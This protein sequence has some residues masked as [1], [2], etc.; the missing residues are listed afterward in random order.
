MTASTRNDVPAQRHIDAF[1]EMMSAERGAAA[2]TLDAYGRDLSAY[3]A[4]LLVRRRAATEAAPADVEAFAAAMRS[5][6][7]SRAT[8]MRRLSAVRQ[9]HRFLYAEQVAADNPAAGVASPRRARPLP[10]VL[11]RAEVEAMLAAA[12]EAVGRPASPARRLKALKVRC[13]VELLAST[14]L[15][16][17]ELLALPLRTA[18]VADGIVDVRGKGGR[19]RLVPVSARALDAAAAYAGAV[20]DDCDTRKRPLPR[21]LFPGRDGKAA[22]TRQAAALEL[23]ALAISAGLD[24][25]RVHPHVL[26]HAFA[27]RLV[28]AGADLRAVQQLL[29][30][31]DISTT[32]IYTHVAGER[33]RQVVETHH[34]LAQ[35]RTGQRRG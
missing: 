1:L 24:P 3:A 19:E 34:P 8:Q 32:Q 4:F 12:A 18:Q 9:F 2:N 11:T 23:K 15:R 31:A 25:A 10:D 35:A 13:L 30:H 33:L 28:D 21:F 22:M 29:G 20:K 17:S 5:E 6:G 14:G 27:T 26:R 16:V 7:L